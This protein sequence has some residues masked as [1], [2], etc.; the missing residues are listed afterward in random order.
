MLR[1]SVFAVLRKIKPGF[2][3]PSVRAALARRLN[4]ASPGYANGQAVACGSDHSASPPG[5]LNGAWHQRR[6]G[7]VGI[8]AAV[9]A[10]A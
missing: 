2:K 9:K 3:T 8:T 7:F 4:L 5:R 6:G 1:R 10:A